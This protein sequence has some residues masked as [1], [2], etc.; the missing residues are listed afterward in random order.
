[1]SCTEERNVLIAISNRVQRGLDKIPSKSESSGLFPPF[2][3]RES[4]KGFKIQDLTYGSLTSIVRLLWCIIVG[5]VSKLTQSDYSDFFFI[6]HFSIF[7]FSTNAQDHR[8]FHGT[9]GQNFDFDLWRDHQE[10]L[11]WTSQLWVGG[12]KEPILGYVTKND[13]KKNLT[14]NG[15]IYNNKDI[16]NLINALNN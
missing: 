14:G 1:M 12:R 8:P 10:N 4:L 2:I 15:L 16:L 11:L 5:L 6:F 13:E 7:H 3:R 9:F